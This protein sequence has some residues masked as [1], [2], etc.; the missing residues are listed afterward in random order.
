M[1]SININGTTLMIVRVFKFSN[2]AQLE[3]GQFFPIDL[4]GVDAMGILRD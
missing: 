3:N 4:I 2:V 1:T